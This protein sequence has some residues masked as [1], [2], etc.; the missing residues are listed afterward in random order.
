M[1]QVLGM[2]RV[3]I[4]AG[5]LGLNLVVFALT[6]FFM[7]PQASKMQR[8]LNA[9]RGQGNSI[10]QEI[11]RL[12]YEFAQIGDQQVMFEQI[13]EDG[14]FTPQGRRQAEQVLRMAQN[15]SGVFTAKVAIR[16][17]ER[18]NNEQAD[19][20]DHAILQSS[21]NI[22]IEAYDDVDVFR[23][24]YLLRNNFPGYLSVDGLTLLRTQD[25]SVDI[26]RNVTLEKP[27]VPVGATLSFIW[28][29]MVP[30]NVA[31]SA[32]NEGGF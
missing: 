28:R 6:Y 10:Q 18:E 4:L 32:N 15:E 25:L 2:Q 20:A 7:D 11:D 14:F 30:E 24:I 16:P 21:V 8:Q 5:L 9:A 23:Y 17:A 3:A 27:P 29:T 26:L 1:I 12:Q 31:P 22:R 13:K 19:K